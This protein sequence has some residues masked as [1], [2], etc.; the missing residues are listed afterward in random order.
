M[1]RGDPQFPGNLAVDPIELRGLDKLGRYRVK[2]YGQVE[3]QKYETEIIP[4]VVKL[5][6]GKYVRS[7]NIPIPPYAVRVKALRERLQMNQTAFAT[8][9]GVGQGAVSKWEKGLSRPIPDALIA[10]ARLTDQEDKFFFLEAAGVP[11]AFFEGAKMTP[12]EAEDATKLVASSL[13]GSA[14]TLVLYRGGSGPRSIPLIKYLHQL[15]D[16]NAVVDYTLSLPSNWLPKGADIQAAKLAHEISP[17]I[18]GDLIALVDISRRDPDRL[19]GSIIIARTPEGNRPMTLRKDGSSYLLI[20][21][22]ESALHPAR[23][24]RQS[25][26][27]SIIGRVVKWIGDAPEGGAPSKARKKPVVPKVRK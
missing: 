12:G 4:A 13:S 6:R 10:L 17:Y 23:I 5:S 27:W 16:H 7:K 11:P 8:A 14:E 18:T 24:L 20:P 2:L 19:A 1:L 21:L 15:G 22:H 3:P 9:I 25:G 26:D